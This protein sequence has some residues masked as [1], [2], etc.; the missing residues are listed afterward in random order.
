MT[1]SAVDRHVYRL[2]SEEFVVGSHRLMVSSDYD[3]SLM[4]DVDSLKRQ[5]YLQLRRFLYSFALD[6][7]FLLFFHFL[8]HFFL[9]LLT[10]TLMTGKKD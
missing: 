3:S 5:S 1:E 6:G 9:L 4:D 10:H 7:H 8:S 2:L